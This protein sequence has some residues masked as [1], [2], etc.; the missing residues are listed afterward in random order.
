MLELT[1]ISTDDRFRMAFYQGQSDRLVLSCSGVGT[2]RG[3][4]P[5]FEFTRAASG[6]GAHSVLFVSDATRSWLSTP[7]LQVEIV[8]Q[9]ETLIGQ[10]Q[11]KTLV[12][13]GNSMGGF[14]ALNLSRVLPLDVTIA[15]TPQFSVDKTIVPEEKRWQ[16]F[17]NQIAKFS[18]PKVENLPQSSGQHYVFH[19]GEQGEYIH[20]SRFPKQENL[21]HYIFPELDH[22]IAR[23]LKNQDLLEPIVEA[24]VS[25]QP[26]HVRELTK[27]AGGE[28]RNEEAF[29][30]C[31]EMHRYEEIGETR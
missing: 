14:M 18:V 26:R 6:D 27:R 15:F 13:M 3:E 2:K 17:R 25:N 22:N 16:F 10:L 9:M 19:G 4:M 21:R 7:G 31:R 20:W 28:W 23:T 11:P 1:P 5:P 8:E 29:E 12:A 24:C 30:R